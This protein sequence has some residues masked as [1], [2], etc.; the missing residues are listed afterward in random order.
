M[1]I[2]FV[3]YNGFVHFEIAIASYLMSSKYE[4]FY[5]SDTFNEVYSEE[6]MKITPNK[7]FS[8]EL[9]NEIDVLIVA[10]GDESNII[11]NQELLEIIKKAN[12]N[13]KIIA[14]ICS[15]V[16]ILLK[17]GILNNHKYTTSIPSNELKVYKEA[18][19]I[20]KK[21]VISKNI[22]SSKANGYIDFALELGKITNL[23]E[24]E[25]DFNETVNFFKP[26]N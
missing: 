3:I 23:Y 7:I 26:S 25:E 20:N 15:G 21:V 8:K 12:E 22:I 2:G 18:K 4:V 10:G 1:K 19:I 5:I 17:S 11:K 24:N 13:K 14:G 9:E 6:G 16:M